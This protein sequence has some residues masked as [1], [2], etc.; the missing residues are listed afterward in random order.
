MLCYNITNKTV[1]C[2][3]KKCN[4]GGIY[5]VQQK[6]FVWYGT[7]IHGILPKVHV[8]N[9]SCQSTLLKSQSLINYRCEHCIHTCNQS[10]ISGER[11]H[12]SSSE[13]DMDLRK[14]I[15]KLTDFATLS[16]AESWDNVGLLVEPSPPHTVKTVYLTNDLT[17]ATLDEAIKKN[18]DL[19]VSYHPPIFTPLK[20]LTQQS[21]KERLIVKCIENRI[22]LYSPHTSYDALQG[23]VNDW[24]IQAFG[25]IN[26]FNILSLYF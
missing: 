22:A 8:L 18:V 3:F 23:G 19:I 17:T 20:R 16:L 15:N 4:V 14:V 25:M 2:L 24:L 9:S 10:D 11:V 1:R 7:R 6:L 13:S 26:S 5:F 21:W 12:Y